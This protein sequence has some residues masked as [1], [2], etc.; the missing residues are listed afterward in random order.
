V[1][2]TAISVGI[3]A[4]N[5]S[6][7]DFCATTGF[8]SNLIEEEPVVAIPPELEAQIL[9]YYHAEH[10]RIGTIATQ[11]GVHHGTVSRVLAQAD[12]PPAGAARRPS[13]IDAYLPF[14]LETLAQ[15]PKLTA[16]RLYAMVQDRG[17]AGRPDHFRHLIARHRPRPKA[18]AYLRL[19]T[20]PG[21]Q[22]QV[23]WGHF[24]HLQIGRARRPLMAFVMV[25]SWS[26]QIY[27]R[28]FLNARMENFLRGHVGAFEAW[29]GLPRVLLYDN[30]KS[31]VLERRGQ[32]IRFNPGLLAI[33]GHYR[34]E[35]RPV[36]VA[37]GN[38]KGRVERAIRY[39][40]D[41]FFAGRTYTDLADLNAQAWTNGPAA[42]RCCP[43]DTTLSVRDAFAQESPR[44]LGLPENPY[45]T[46]E[47]VA[48]TV[49]KSPYVRFDL[50]DYSV[51][52]QQ[53][54][55]TL[56]VA[57]TPEQVR[58]L[59][60][61]EVLATHPRSYDSGAQVE[62]LD[63]IEALAQR[64]HQASR[65][66]ATDR[67]VQAAPRS[68]D[69]LVRAAERGHPLGAITSALLRLLDRFGA[70]EL[71]A[72]IEEALARDVPHSNAV[73]HALEQRREAREAP[74]PVGIVLPDHVQQRDIPV[75]PHRLETYDQITEATHDPD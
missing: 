1:P 53:V 25:L 70:A 13:H 65:H 39:I 27:L 46:D 36:A 14:I 15:F 38:E 34:F 72:G 54:Q 6:A 60:G 66:R 74:P 52:H 37:R 5:S 31:A 11:L 42:E 40:R 45:P 55:R 9:R 21:E 50:N 4:R 64:K 30:L 59:D 47:N 17:Y 71:Q 63:H 7:R 73:R 12:L 48:V 75:Q 44:L 29:G 22:A 8:P 28:F 61:Q 41:A 49:G 58:I 33:A 26:R 67:L 10:W 43:E 2:C 3:A 69:L 51:P 56:T 62:I 23:D 32:A 57:A 18:E 68:R 20:L 24:G 19:R 16:S 35:P